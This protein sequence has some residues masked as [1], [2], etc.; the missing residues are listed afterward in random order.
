[1]EPL[2]VIGL[3]SFGILL[4]LVVFLA[5]PHQHERFSDRA[6]RLERSAAAQAEVED[7]DIEQMIEA[8]NDIRRRR[9][10]PE[11]GDDLVAELSRPTGPR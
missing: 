3:G 2:V 7:T 10:L 9:G 5:Q 6:G 11:I 4:T 1:M 8:R